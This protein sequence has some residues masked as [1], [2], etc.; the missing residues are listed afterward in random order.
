MK[1]RLHSIVI[2]ENNFNNACKVAKDNKAS[3]WDC[4]TSIKQFLNMHKDKD[5]EALFNVA[6]LKQTKLTAL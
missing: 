5:K 2:N 4:G 1:M 6:Y 3:L